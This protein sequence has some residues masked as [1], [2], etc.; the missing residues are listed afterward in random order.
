MVLSEF[1]AMWQA[2]GLKFTQEEC[3]VKDTATWL[4]YA[5]EEPQSTAEYGRHYGLMVVHDSQGNIV[6]HNFKNIRSS[7]TKPW[8]EQ[9]YG[10][11]E[12]HYAEGLI[13]EQGRPI[14]CA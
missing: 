11:F 10:W 1:L 6:A 13:D 8:R 5:V 12:E 3:R 14:P 7:D 2:D 9:I 4:L